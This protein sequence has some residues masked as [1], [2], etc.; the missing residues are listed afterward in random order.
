M[1]DKGKRVELKEG[2]EEEEGKKVDLVDYLDSEG[3][4]FEFEDYGK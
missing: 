1:F 3:E 4:D 2:G